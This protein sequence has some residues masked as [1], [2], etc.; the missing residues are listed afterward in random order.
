M[1][2]PFAME[3]FHWKRCPRKFLPVLC[4][5]RVDKFLEIENKLQQTATGTYIK[6]VEWKYSILVSERMGTTLEQSRQ[7][8]HG[9]QVYFSSISFFNVLLSMTILLQRKSLK[10]VLPKAR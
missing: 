9:T 6:Q 7:H 1:P 8:S 2:H 5:K 10:K 4:V 3:K